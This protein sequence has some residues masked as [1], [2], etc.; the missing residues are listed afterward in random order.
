MSTS[1][2]F[3]QIIALH[4]KYAPADS[5]FESVFTHCKI[6]SDIAVQ[7]AKKSGVHV[8]IE[9]VKAGCLLHDIGV[10][11]LFDEN[12]AE[13]DAGKYIT[14]GV[15]GEEILRNE[16]FAEQYCRFASHHTGA[17]ITKE[18]IRQNNLPLPLSDYLAETPEEEL[19]MYADKFHSKTKPPMFNSHKFYTN[20]SARFG[21]EAE[22]RF[23][24]LTKKFG[25][26]DLVPLIAAYRHGLRG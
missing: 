9:L 26:P 11:A 7:L 15:R 21:T 2:T 13:I 22:S 25:K 10:Y 24:N 14:H 5:V 8:D 17:G 16:G 3:D 6:V 23:A 12:G 18:Q 20:Y 4:K 19:V 1:T